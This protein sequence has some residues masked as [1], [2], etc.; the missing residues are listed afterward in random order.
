MILTAEKGMTLHKGEEI[1][2]F[3]FGGSDIIMLFEAKSNV[4]FTAQPGVHYTMG[5]K[6]AQAHPVMRPKAPRPGV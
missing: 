1:S 4:S 2:Y 6:I 3:Q 5:T